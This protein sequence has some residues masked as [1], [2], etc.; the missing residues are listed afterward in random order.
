MAPSRHARPPVLLSSGTRLGPRARAALLALACVA[1]LAGAGTARAEIALDEMKRVFVFGDLRLRL[2]S[3]WSST[4]PDGTERDDR[5]RARVRGRLGFRYQPTDHV[6]FLVRARSGNTNSQ[7]SPH[8]TIVQSGDNGDG[9]ILVD[10]AWVQFK[11]KRGW[12]SIGRNGMPFWS[13]NEQLF[14]EDI[15]FDGAGFGFDW[16]EKPDKHMVRGALGSLPEGDASLSWDEEGLL[17]GVQY[18]WQRAL[19]RGSVTVAAGVHVVEDDDE[20]ANPVLLDQ[21]YCIWALSF[22]RVFKAGELPL[23]LGVD[24]LHNSDAPPAGTWNRDERD[25]YVLSFQAGS[26]KEKGDWL[27]GYWF[28]HVEKFAVVPFLAQDDWMRWGSATQTRSSNYDGHELRLAYTFTKSMNLVARLFM[29]DGVE[30]ESP[31]AIAKEDGMRFR[32]DFN[33]KF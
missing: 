27:V 21:D 18:A 19:E 17:M 29:V 16:G 2:E 8:V 26:T 13:Q 32:L 7:G 33:W 30:L 14:D 4:A 28:A 11:G 15:W 22:Q 24:V 5:D 3:D 9:D 10:R 20:V 1:S 6:G 25:G 31:V 23:T 12:A